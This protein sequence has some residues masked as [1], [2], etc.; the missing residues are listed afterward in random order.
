MTCRS[1]ELIR[2][3]TAEGLVFTGHIDSIEPRYENKTV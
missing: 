1:E 3:S 2:T